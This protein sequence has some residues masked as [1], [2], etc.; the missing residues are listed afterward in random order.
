LHAIEGK[1]AEVSAVWELKQAVA[2][3]CDQVVEES[4]AAV[5]KI[6]VNAARL[7]K[8]DAT[9]LT[10]SRS[11]TVSET[12]KQAVAMGKGIRVIVT[13]SRPLLE[14][15]VVAEELSDLGVPVTFVVDSAIGTLMA[16][17]DLC[18]V[19]TDSVLFDGSIVNKIGTYPLA[20]TARE[21]SK[22]FYVVCEKSKLNLRSIFEPEFEIEE[23]DPSE[24]LP[25]PKKSLITVSNPYFDRTPGKFVS[26]LITEDG[27]LS[28]EELPA[29]FRKM[30]AE[31]CI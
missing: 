31:T 23:K 2:V 8:D 29:V 12:L 18:L 30:V 19:G 9:I 13:E 15:R 24:V 27:E 20:V 6:A 17:A 5:H 10:H 14:G 28:V 4:E 21:H 26:K 25:H 16:T 7:I 11:S 1:A 22:P 3:I